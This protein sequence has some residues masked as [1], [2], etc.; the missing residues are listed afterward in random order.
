MFGC[1]ACFAKTPHWSL[2][3]GWIGLRS[4]RRAAIVTAPNR[5][6]KKDPRKLHTVL[7][8]LP[9]CPVDLG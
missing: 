4:S 9:L 5:A 3:A 7:A 8:R 1:S 2:N 6:V